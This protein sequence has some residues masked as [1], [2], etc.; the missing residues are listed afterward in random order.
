[1]DAKKKASLEAGR[2]KVRP[3]ARPPGAPALPCSVGGR[4]GDGGGR[5]MGAGGGWGVA[6]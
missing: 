5:G 4:E 1:M 2:R 3:P 6:T